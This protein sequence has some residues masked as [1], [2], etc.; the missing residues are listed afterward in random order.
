MVSKQAALR[1][2]VPAEL[3]EWVDNRLLSAHIRMVR[4]LVLGTLLNAAVAMLA[5]TGQA[6]TLLVA[7]FGATMIAACL[8]RLW[9]AEG[10]ERGR[11]RRNT[12]KIVLAFELNSLWLGL[13][14]GILVAIQLPLVSPGVQLLLAVCTVSQVASAAYTI[15]TLPRAALIYV[16]AQAA[17]LGIGLAQL[18]TLPAV[19]TIA[20]LG[21][22]SILL[23]QMAYAAHNL[24][25]FVVRQLCGS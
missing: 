22:A 16:A 15:R 5:L 21:T 23:V 20:V 8:H 6:P 14:L 25:D 18:Q 24:F 9:L 12:G 19:G 1:V 17:G 13:N 2:A 11:R 3:R 7:L 4:A 10:I